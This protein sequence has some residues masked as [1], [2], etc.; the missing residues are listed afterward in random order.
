M[1]R[2]FV[3]EPDADNGGEDEPLP[4]DSPHPYYLTPQGVVW[5]TKRLEALV[6][7]RNAITV[8]VTEPG[9][10]QRRKRLSREIRLLERKQARAIAID[11][12]TQP[13]NKV[14]FGHVVTV[15]DDD[16]KKQRFS[17]VGEDEATPQTGRIS[18]LS[19][20]AQALL[21]GEIEERVI[22]RRPAGDI[23]LTILSID[24][25]VSPGRRHP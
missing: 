2:A 4:P 18:W 6:A 21:G 19:P 7:E 20:L 9:E 11:P 12:A 23:S 15:E 22:W 3:R 10:A 1:S 25:A 24:D 16:G 5:L 14:S 13:K 17:I 8:G